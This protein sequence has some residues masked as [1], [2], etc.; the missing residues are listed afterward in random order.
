MARKA[1]TGWCRALTSVA[2]AQAGAYLVFPGKPTVATDRSL[3][4][5]DGRKLGC[6]CYPQSRSILR[7]SVL[8][9]AESPDSTMK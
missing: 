6:E 5:G 2:P 4:W 3:R 1:E 9:A 7:P 8:R